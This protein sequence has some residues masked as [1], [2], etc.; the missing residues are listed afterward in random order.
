MASFAAVLA[1]MNSHADDR[2]ADD[3]QIEG[4]GAMAD[5][6]AVFAGDHIQAE[7]ETGFDIPIPA[8]GPEH[9]L[10]TDLGGGARTD[11]VFGLDALGGFALAV[12]AAGQAGGLLHEGETDGGGG[13]VK[14][15]QATRLGAAAVELTG[16]RYRRLG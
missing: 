8:V 3:R 6:T 13:G 9:L 1:P 5:P 14:S 2:A 11:Q 12:A 10:G 7:V 15:D 4:G 16:L